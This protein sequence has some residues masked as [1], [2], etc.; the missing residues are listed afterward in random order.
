[1]SSSF[2]TQR[3]HTKF[4][5]KIQTRI[6]KKQHLIRQQRS[7]RDAHCRKP[8]SASS[9]THQPVWGKKFPHYMGNNIAVYMLITDTAQAYLKATSQTAVV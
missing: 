7:L 5:Q 3:I 6:F 8:S 1:M 4:T 2:I 9:N